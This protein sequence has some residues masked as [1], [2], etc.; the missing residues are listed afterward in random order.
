MDCNKK[1]GYLCTP[2]REVLCVILVQNEWKENKLKIFSKK[3][4]RAKKIL[5]FAPAKRKNS[6]I[7]K[8]ETFIDILN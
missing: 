6:G 4:A 2:P 1:D 5:T 7:K 8:E 3:L